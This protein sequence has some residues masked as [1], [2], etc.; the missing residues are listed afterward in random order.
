MDFQLKQDGSK[1]NLTL[2][3]DIAGLVPEHIDNDEPMRIE[4]VPEITDDPYQFAKIVINLSR[5]DNLSR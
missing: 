1:L 2:A 3:C 4:V 5:V